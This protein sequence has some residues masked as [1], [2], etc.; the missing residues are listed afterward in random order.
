MI[1]NTP[2]TKTEIAAWNSHRAKHRGRRRRPAVS[3][4]SIQVWRAAIA[5]LDATEPE[6]RDTIER[7]LVNVAGVS[8][9]RYGDA[10][11]AVDVVVK[12]VAKIRTKAIK[13]AFRRIR[14]TN[15]V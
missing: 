7:G 10:M 1:L 11:K 15:G 9:A 4:A 2:D 6:V 14:K 3:A 13:D 8:G 12:R 5:A